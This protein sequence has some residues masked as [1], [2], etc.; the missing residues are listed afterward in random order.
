MSFSWET[1]PAPTLTLRH[2][3]RTRAFALRLPPELF[4]LIALAGTLNLW[5]LSRNGWANDYYAA[6]VRSMSSS[7]HNFLFGSLDASGVMTVDKSPLAL[8]IQSLSVR[9]FGYHSLSI[10][11]PQALIGVVTVALLYD[12]VRRRFG[13]LGGFVAG[14]ALAL[15][16]ITVAI[17]RHNNPDALLV[18]CCVAALWCTVR[19]LEAEVAR[20][21][22]RWLVLA[23]IAVG[24]GFETKMAVALMVVPGIV[25]AW[26]WIAP[27]DGN[28]THPRLHALRQLLAGGV[29][30]VL[31]GGAWP[32][33]VE[34]T[35]AADRPWI[36]GT[37]DNRILSLIS[38]YNGVGRIDGQTGGPGGFGG[39]SV[40]GGTAGPL[41]LL[42]S[43]LGGQAGW[44]LGFALVSGI[45]I[46]VASRL[47]R[48]DPRSGWLIAVGG[49]LLVTGVVFSD[50]K[51][52]FHPYYVSLLA[53]F[54]AALVGA[55]TA[56]LLRGGLNA[57]IVGPFALIAGV[58]TEL[59]VL[60]QYSGELTWLA[61]VLIAVGV[62]AALALAAFA[63]RRVRMV[64]LGV[65]L[66][67]L[68]IAPGAWAV[69]TLGHA[70]SG[71]FPAGGPGSAAAGGFG[72]F[73]GPGARG[74][75]LGRGFARAGLHAGAGAGGQA[76]GVQ[77]FGSGG[78]ARSGT[79]PGASKASGAPQVGS[80]AGAGVPGVGG[81]PSGAAAG[82]SG[83]A[84]AGTGIPVP[85]TGNVGF[86]GG[87]GGGRGGFGAR[88]FGG[89]PGGGGGP[90]SGENLSN[91]VLGYVKQHGGGTIA[92]ASQ[93]SA[94]SAIIEKDAD[95][96]GIGGFSGRESDVSI[97]WLAD[98]VA[99]GKIRWVLAGEQGGAGAGRLLGGTSAGGLPGDTRKG[100][101]VAIAAAAKVCR[102]VT[103]TAASGTGATGAS[104]GT[105]AVAGT[106]GSASTS[107][108][109]DCQ[110]RAAQL[111]AQESRP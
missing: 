55:G 98:E 7:W 23:G 45:G 107:T 56:Q 53:P 101:S 84:G 11:V 43:A 64:A 72:G 92:V 47:R 6:A 1:R 31:V 26:L 54:I 96:A 75:L 16:P 105:T 97:S 30:M 83:V 104:E 46:L 52:I 21:Q 49:A 41:R 68:L 60:S 37:S 4:G 80:S 70:T 28:P 57:R 29:A 85:P 77:L 33:L 24:L 111:S 95:V 36:S 63:E 40:F 27:A 89:G 35:P 78:A 3:T 14:L 88:G 65:A 106:N 25:A 74:R 94:A 2:R 5:A 66:A 22:T 102:K 79:G 82:G 110:G 48:A 20:A 62:L 109:Y 38:E 61:P 90:G 9:V 15:T 17:S 87:L 69:E 50:A 100:S 51:G 32:L 18:L 58:A 86:A 91:E 76:G 12:L 71:T 19:A 34:L 13:R 59:A 44:L 67:V 99:A 93:S 39:G 108:L 8:W 81:V 73:G 42:N 103:L 10:L